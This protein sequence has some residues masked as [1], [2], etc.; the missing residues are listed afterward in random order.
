MVDAV[1]QAT[2]P[3]SQPGDVVPGTEGTVAST[4]PAEGDTGKAP[5]E[6]AGDPGEPKRFTQEELDAIVQQRLAKERRR[7]ERE[8]A[9]RSTAP[10]VDATRDLRQE[11]FASV[12]EYA[13]ALAEQKAAIKLAQREQT[14]H[15]QQ[16]AEAFADREDSARE[17]YQDYDN[18]V[19]NQNVPI[20]EAMAMAIREADNG[21][22]IAYF[23]GANPDDARRISRLNPFL[24]AKEI[25]RIEQRLAAEPPAPRK[26]SSAPAPIR[27][28]KANTAAPITDT[29][30]PRSIASM[31]P[32]E[33]IEAERA[34][35]R[36]VW[37]Q[38]RR[39]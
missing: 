32:T 22:D 6:A 39:H 9:A 24:Q 35:Q 19:Y 26:Q 34:R 8:H 2:D 23:L 4:T 37:E 27:P 38:S 25:G 21:P 5:N 14:Q 10:A 1:T 16:V 3:A 17:R 28:V 18:V 7:M 29:T 13:D 31:T 20:T 12:E 15:Q 36:R 30:D 33:W 11:D